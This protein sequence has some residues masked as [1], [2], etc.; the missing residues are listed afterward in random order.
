M[1][2]TIAMNKTL[3]ERQQRRHPAG[4]VVRPGPA[5]RQAG[6]GA[7]AAGAADTAVF[8]SLL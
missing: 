3:Q 4:G 6:W 8:C 1:R 2:Q 7:A 5:R